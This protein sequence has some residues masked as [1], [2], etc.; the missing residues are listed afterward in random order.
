MHASPPHRSH[1]LENPH[2]PATILL[3]VVAAGRDPGPD[4]WHGRTGKV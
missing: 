1:P 4:P 3:A 2:V